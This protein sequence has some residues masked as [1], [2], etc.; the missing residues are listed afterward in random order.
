M[1]EWTIV[2]LH[3]E[4]AEQPDNDRWLLIY[5]VPV[6][7]AHNGTF[8]VS[9]PKNMLTDFAATYGYDLDSPADVDDMWDHLIHLPYLRES[10]RREG[11]GHETTTN[12]YEMSAQAARQLA[13]DQVAE[14]KKRRRIV[15]TPRPA[16]TAVHLSK[17]AADDGI[18]G[19]VRRDMLARTHA[20]TARALAAEKATA[21]VVVQERMMMLA[22]RM[23]ASRNG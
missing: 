4:I 21:R 22:T 14:L 5:Q 8:S 3:D 7:Y 12:P 1:E 13:R 23:N 10:G 20:G 19:L 9:M 17:A 18:L 16:L 11:R 15:E 2:D 6:E